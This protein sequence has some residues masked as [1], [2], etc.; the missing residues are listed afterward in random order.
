MVSLR[1]V[2]RSFQCW[3]EGTSW[4]A[5]DGRVKEGE[6]APREQSLYLTGSG[7]GG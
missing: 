1:N 3:G 4:R 7:R 5:W 6:G 2:C